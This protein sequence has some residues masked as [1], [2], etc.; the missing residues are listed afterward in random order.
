MKYITLPPRVTLKDNSGTPIPQD[1]V[2]GLP[3]FVADFTLNDKIFGD[4]FKSILAGSRILDAFAGKE[5][6]AVVVLDDADHELLR[7]A[8][9]APSAA[10][11]PPMI[12]RQYLP[13]MRAVMDAADRDP[14]QKDRE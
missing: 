2:R 6:G 12:A 8:V 10:M 13:L 11:L 3:E 14:S 5:E 4:G 7:K 9:Q 1:P